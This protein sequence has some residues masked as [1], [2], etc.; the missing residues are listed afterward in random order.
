[1]QPMLQIRKDKGLCW[2]RAG[3]AESHHALVLF[4]GLASNASRWREFARNAMRDSQLQGWKILMPDL[5]GH[6]ASPRRGRVNIE[7]WIE[8]F[9]EMLGREQIRNFIVGGHCMG[10]NL[11]LHVAAR[12]PAGLAGLI[13]IEPM[14]PEA[15]AGFAARFGRFRFIL[16]PLAALAGALNWFGIGRRTFPVLD[17]EQSDVQA[18]RESEAAGGDFVANYASPFRDLRYMPTASY[19]AALHQTLRPLPEPEVID[20]PVL[21]LLSAGGLFGG[22]SRT[23]AWLERIGQAEI[24]ELDARHWIPTEQPDEMRARIADFA[25]G[26]MMEPTRQ[27]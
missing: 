3:E 2:L 19:L 21:A 7:T 6:G 18:R 22:P 9:R 26:T 1:M 14:V 8:D 10:A 20:C 13:L 12:R 15:R 5:R 11:A 4:H 27:D 25:R 17:L 16:P 24:A 23:R